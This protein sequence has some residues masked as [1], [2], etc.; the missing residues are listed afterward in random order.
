MARHPYW[1]RNALHAATGQEARG[2]FANPR[3][4]NAAARNLRLTGRSPAIDSANSA[5][6]GEQLTDVLGRRRVDDRSVRNTGGGPRRYDDRG[7][8]EFQP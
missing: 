8:Y 7:A 3:F 5:A 6:P 4:A 1:N 2:V